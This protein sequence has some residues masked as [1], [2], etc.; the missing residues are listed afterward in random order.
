VPLTV[1]LGGGLEIP[2]CCLNPHRL[3]AG[4]NEEVRKGEASG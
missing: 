3:V 4:K 1:N 2:Q